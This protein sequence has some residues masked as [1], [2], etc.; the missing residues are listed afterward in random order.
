[1]E[2]AK[3]ASISVT[4]TMLQV[5]DHKKYAFRRIAR[6]SPDKPILIYG[7]SARTNATSIWSQEKTWLDASTHTGAMA[8]KNTFS[9]MAAVTNAPYSTIKTNKKA[10]WD[11]EKSA[12]KIIVMDWGSLT[13]GKYW[14]GMGTVINV[15]MVLCVFKLLHQLKSV[16]RLQIKMFLILINS[17]RLKRSS[18]QN[19]KITTSDLSQISR[20]N[21][22]DIDLYMRMKSFIILHL[23]QNYSNTFH[24]EMAS[25]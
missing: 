7:A 12:F 6:K 22:Q 17:H 8:T 25:T 20:E 11:M 2:N 1:M 13:T 9:K 14:T 3:I 4:L 15:R 21:T 10:L 18:K 24:K 23:A 16:K 19:A 5:R